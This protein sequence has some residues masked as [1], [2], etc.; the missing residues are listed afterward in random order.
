MKFVLRLYFFIYL[1][2]FSISAGPR[3]RHRIFVK[4]R[5]RMDVGTEWGKGEYFCFK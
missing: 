4:P 3:R 5:I 2:F 1:I